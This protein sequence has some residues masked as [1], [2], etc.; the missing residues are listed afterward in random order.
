ME[1]SMK[2]GFRQDINGLRAWA[3]V[4]V[5]L[6]HFGVPGFSGGFVGVDIFFVISGFLMT[7]IIYKGLTEDSFSILDF[8]LAR[9]K[10]IIPELLALCGVLLI[11]GWQFLPAIEY[12]QLGKHVFGAATFPI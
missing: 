9:A 11:L 8:Y 10:R 6:F 12:E 5:I 4:V 2:A 1:G 7:G 3:V